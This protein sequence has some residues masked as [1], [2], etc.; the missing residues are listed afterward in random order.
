[1]ESGRNNMF[2][3]FGPAAAISR[4]MNFGAE[5]TR[6]AL[7]LSFSFAVGDGQCALDGA[8]SLRLQQGIVAQGALLSGLLTSRGFTGAKEFLMGRYG[9]LRAFEPDPRLEFLC[10]NFGKYFYGEDITIKPFSACRATHS[11]I[12]L[13]LRL[14]PRIEVNEIDRVLIHTCPQCLWSSS[15]AVGGRASRLCSRSA[16]LH[17]FYRCGSPHP[18]RFFPTGT[19]T[20]AS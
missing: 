12:A 15:Q 17:R 19:G 18:R 4:A 13:A 9:Y 11:S 5:E 20:P 16:I 2:K 10:D 6:N 1:M 3:I 8:L 7:G 14:R